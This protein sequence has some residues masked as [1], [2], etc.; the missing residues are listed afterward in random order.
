MFRS[1]RR[2]FYVRQDSTLVTSIAS[3]RLKT[4]LFFSFYNHVH[5][6]FVVPLRSQDYFR[7]MFLCIE[8]NVYD[9]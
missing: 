2:D 6:A 7:D 5:D 9:I 4:V 1:V 3:L 8:K